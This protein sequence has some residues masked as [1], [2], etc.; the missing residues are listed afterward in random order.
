MGSNRVDKMKDMVARSPED[1]RP[2]YFL[3]HELFRSGD[4]AG[5]AKHYQVYLDLAPDEEGAG[6]RDYGQCLERLGRS[7]EAAEAYRRGIQAA[8]AHRHEGLAGE[9]AFLLEQIEDAAS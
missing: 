1:P 2:R 8:H 3:A 6:Y 4:W 5:A 9:I 7:Q